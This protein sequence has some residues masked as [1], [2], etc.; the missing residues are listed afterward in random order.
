MRPLLVLSI[1]TVLLSW[2]GP[3]SAAW[4]V[5]GSFCANCWTPG[6]HNQLHDDGAHGDGAAGDGVFGVDI[7][8]DQPPGP[9][10]WFVSTESILGTSFPQL[11]CSPPPTYA[12]LY[13]S[14]AG[15]VVHFSFDTRDNG[16]YPT[17]AVAT[18]HAWPTAAP[19]EAVLGYLLEN[20][21]FHPTVKTGDVWT[22]T[23]MVP[24]AGSHLYAFRASDGSEYFAGAYNGL[25]GCT[26]GEHAQTSFTTTVP[27]SW[28][29]LHFDESVGRMRAEVVDVTSAKPA[30][31]GAVKSI[32]R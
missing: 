1:G 7:V 6:S 11:W 23:V 15:E 22:A 20:P 25:T 13:T 30:T 26:F 5:Y 29:R 31:W 2:A 9:F 14:A 19:L 10:Q 21:T 3:A 28:V 16:W 27:N 8:V 12:A 18:D 17:Y 4:Y 32:Y 24:L